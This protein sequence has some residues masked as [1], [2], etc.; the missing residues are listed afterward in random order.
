M[1]FFISSFILV[2]CS[3]RILRR[4]LSVLL[5]WGTVHGLFAQKADTLCAVQQA[6]AHPSTNHSRIDALEL[7]FSRGNVLITDQYQRAW[8]RGTA[9]TSV[10]L[11]VRHRTLRDSANVFAPDYNYPTWGVALQWTNLTRATMQ[12]TASPWWGQL[13]PVDYASHAGH[14]FAL[15]GSFSR[16]LQRRSWG[17]WGYALEEG[18]AFNTRPYNKELNADNELTGSPLLFHF[19]ASVYG[20]V[21]LSP[22]WS[23]RADLAFRHV[24]N[25]ATH[26]PNKGAN[27]WQ[28]TLAVQY[29]LHPDAARQSPMKSHAMVSSR[30]EASMKSGNSVGF[31]PYWFAHIEGNVGMR[32]LL[33]TWL[34]TQYNTAPS[35]LSYR[36]DRF[37]RYF[38]YNLQTDVMHRYARRWATGVGIDVFTLPY[39]NQL[40]QFAPH[41]GAHRTFSP[42]SLGV[43]LKHESY[44]GR[45]ASYVHLGY[46]LYR[47]TGRLPS[48]D[49][50]R[51]YERV[52]LRYRLGRITL[53]ERHHGLTLS[54]GIKAHKLKADFAEIGIGWDF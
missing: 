54:V 21:R 44:Y 5:L 53:G 7:G 40:R 23:L 38:V 45:L 13:A 34:Q 48:S 46:Y 29:T 18:L 25:G 30:E 50:T 43:A 22:Q 51:Y 49:E 24:S 19:G 41:D 15:V 16:P 6:V 8:M 36:T 11:G 14:L 28:P 20:E 31:R 12:K 47:E 1:S 33:E 35:A 42:F 9:L 26:R 52:G 37:H 10:Q 27:M 3:A 17:E 32:T 4:G 39:V 2:S